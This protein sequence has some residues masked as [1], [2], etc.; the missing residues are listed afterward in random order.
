MSVLVAGRIP[1]VAHIHQNPSWLKKISINSIIFTLSTFRVKKIIVVSPTILQDTKMISAYKHK[2]NIIENIVDTNYVNK[3]SLVAEPNIMNFDAV[4]IGRLVDVKDPLRF[5]KIISQVV[6]KHQNVKAGIIGDG[7]L[8]SACERYIKELGL[9][10]TVFL[11][12]HVDNPFP[13]LKNSKL[14][15]MTSKTEGLP[16]TA[17]EAL[18]LGKP[19][20]VPDISSMSRLV[21]GKNGVVCE[22]DDQFIAID[23]ILGDPNSYTQMSQDALIKAHNL[24]DMNKFRN[25]ISNIYRQALNKNGANDRID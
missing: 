6:K 21:D 9:D 12:G 14:L 11:H 15:V 18:T 17:I 16:M 25:E 19:I 1:I 20:I 23:K 24:F 4:F 7:V 2:I 5:I 3:M 22:N 8:R 13:I 10:N